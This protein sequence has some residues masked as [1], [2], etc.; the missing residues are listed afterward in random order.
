MIGIDEMTIGVDKGGM[1]SYKDQL[2]ADLLTS[3]AEKLDTAENNIDTSLK[4]GWRGASE[5]KFEKD[6]KE[7][8]K[9]I[10]EDLADEYRDVE[11]RLDDLQNFYYKEDELL[12]ED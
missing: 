1:G 10:K 4:S 12:A 6:L 11:S 8:I 3:V 5:E 7:Q 9:K 2:K